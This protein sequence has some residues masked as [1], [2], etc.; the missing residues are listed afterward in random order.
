MADILSATFTEHLS[1]Y[2]EFLGLLPVFRF[3]IRIAA[4]AL[5]VSFLRL[6]VCQL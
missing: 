5:I 6:R 4:G 2:Q 1:L 3:L